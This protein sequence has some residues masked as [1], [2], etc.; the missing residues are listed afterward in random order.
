MH[1]LCRGVRQNFQNDEISRS[2][3]ENFFLVFEILKNLCMQVSFNHFFNGWGGGFL[4]NSLLNDI[5]YF[6]ENF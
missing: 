3:S 1:G 4:H 6:D 5:Q 2:S